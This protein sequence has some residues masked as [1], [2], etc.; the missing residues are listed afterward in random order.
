MIIKA[1]IFDL[2]GVIYLGRTV[3]P[4]AAEAIAYAR[5]KGIGTYFLTNSGTRSRAGRVEKLKGFGISAKESEIYTSSYLTA[6]YITTHYTEKGKKPKV[7]CIGERGTCE[8]LEKAGIDIV[9]DS[10][11]NIVTVGLERAITYDKFTAAFRA[12]INGADFIARNVDPAFPVEDGLK[13]G[14]GAF[15]KFLEYS[16]GKAPIVI[17][18]PNT[19]GIET[20]IQ[21]HKLKKD[22][23]AIV[24]D[25][26]DSDIEVGKKAGI[27]TILVLSGVTKKKDLEKLSKKEM[28]DKVIESIAE[29]NKLL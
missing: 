1:L 3:V 17:G 19:Y 4:G 26:L 11:A 15:V 20:I 6:K 18:K 5:K 28:P 21:E 9:Q 24:G 12:L 7:F 8:E 10:N 23:V 27:H 2:D 14:A 22:E 29:L 13:P 25:R 16:S